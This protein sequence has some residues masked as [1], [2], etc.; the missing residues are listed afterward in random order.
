MLLL[1]SIRVA[2]WLPV[3]ERAVHS[4]NCRCL[5]WALVKFC[6][7]PSFPFSIEGGIRDVIVL[8][9]DNCLSIYFKPRSCFYMTILVVGRKTKVYSL[10]HLLQL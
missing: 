1:F 2:E 4:V 5:L 7:C 3:W 8:I 9:P 6:M 10:N